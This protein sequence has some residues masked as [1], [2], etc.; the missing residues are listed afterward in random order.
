MKQIAITAVIVALFAAPLAAQQDEDA[1]SLLE[2]GARDFLEG[3]LLEM[4]PAWQ[5]LQRFMEAMGP[6]MLELMDEVKDWSAY[7]APEMLENGDIIIRRKPEGATSD[8]DLPP[9]IEL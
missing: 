5:E 7:E 1:P 3:L 4:E 9:Q 2:Q 8:S 6:A